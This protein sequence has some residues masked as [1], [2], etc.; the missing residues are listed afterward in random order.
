MSTCETGRDKMELYKELQPKDILNSS[1]ITCLLDKDPRTPVK[2]ITPCLVD[3]D[4]L[5]ITY[6]CD[7]DLSN[8]DSMV[9]DYTH[10]H[11]PYP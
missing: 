5:Y 7:M 9:N 3:K 11:E 8:I 4:T 6:P 2:E 1:S 10:E